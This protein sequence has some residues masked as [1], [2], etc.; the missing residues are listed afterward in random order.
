MDEVEHQE[1]FARIPP[2]PLNHSTRCADLATH[3]PTVSGDRR[4]YV[5]LAT[6]RA[7]SF[8]SALALITNVAWER[9]T[10]FLKRIIPVFGIL[11]ALAALA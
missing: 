11:Q 10:Y 5:F 7:K 6:H 1:E 9:I 4:R 3:P 8:A 2:Q